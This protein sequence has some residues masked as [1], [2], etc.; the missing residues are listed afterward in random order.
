MHIDAGQVGGP[1]TEQCVEVGGA[2]CGIL[3][4]RGFIPTVTPDRLAGMRGGVV[5]D[6]L[7]AMALRRR[8]P[9]IQP[10]QRQTGGGEMNVAVD[11]TRRDEAA[12]EIDHLSIG[13]LAA[14]DVVA[15][16]PCHYSV[17]E[18]HRGRI[19]MSRAVHPAV[20]QQRGGDVRHAV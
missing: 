10:G 8:S 20:H 15:T 17:A 2:R 5:G 7:Q 11:E 4:P 3:R 12:V 6:E 9:Q 14:A 19:G 1:I 16:Q 18:R 13:K